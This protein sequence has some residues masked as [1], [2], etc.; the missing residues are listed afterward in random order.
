MLDATTALD[1][2]PNV[3]PDGARSA[4]A[5][6]TVALR[7]AEIADKARNI[8]TRI[9]ADAD[10]LLAPLLKAQRSDLVAESNQIEGY[11]VTREHVLQAV[12]THRELVDGDI[13]TLIQ[14]IRADPKIVNALGLYKA[15]QLA[16]DWAHKGE[17][18][19]AYEM[20]QLHGLITVDERFGGKYRTHDVAIGGTSFRPPAHY[21]VAHS[22][23]TFAAWWQGSTGD[24]VLD[25]T[26]AHAW[27]THIHPYEDGNGRL[28][29][30]LANFVLAQAHYPPLIVRA[31]QDRGEYYAAL[32][33]SDDGNVLPL[34]Q[35]F[36]R[37]IRRT[38]RAMG[39][40]NY[41][42]DY[43]ED[44]LLASVDDQRSAWSALVSVFTTAF[45]RDL[46]HLGWHT[47]SQGV[48]TRASFKFLCDR[49][50]DGNGWF[51][52]VRNQFDDRRYLL[53]FG[54]ASDTLCDLFG[55]KPPGYPSIFISERDMSPDAVHPY[56]WT[57][58]LHGLPDE[59]FL[60]PLEASPVTLRSGIHT[61]RLDIERA[62]KSVA[63]GL[64]ARG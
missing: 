59:I 53:W 42:Q 45:T 47:D 39:S 62:A 54:F 36:A 26:V 10:D 5:F 15:Q 7:S 18:V 43:L 17:R 27:L 19:L 38:V 56:V 6:E 60:K 48:P 11:D 52:V 20:R 61:E 33:A 9:A 31:G 25:A 23:D 55:G 50:P 16:D 29:R 35:L 3:L 24:P 41:T 51:L 22:M 40:P 46:R 30:L 1:G 12:A 49:N 58:A 8:R 28:A 2:T 21:D 32:A 57:P 44:R 34:Y 37:I 14:A 63:A 13:H 4:L 64:V